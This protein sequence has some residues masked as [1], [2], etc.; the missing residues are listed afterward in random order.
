MQDFIVIRGA[1]EN[2]LKNINLKIPR[3]KLNVITGLSGSGKSSLAFDTIYAEGQRRYIESLSSYARQFLGQ[4][5]KPNVESIEGLSPAISIDQKTTSKNPRS[6]VGTVTEIHDYLRL[7]F[8]RIGTPHC[9]ICGSKISKMS[10]DTIVSNILEIKEETKLFIFAPI[11]REKKGEYK[12]VLDAIKREG[13]LRVRVDGKIYS[14]DDDEI[15]P[16]NKQKKHSIDILVDRLMSKNKNNEDYVKRL[17]EGL[18]TAIYK[19]EG[20]V[21]IS[22]HSPK[23]DGS[24]LKQKGKKKNESP[25]ELVFNTKL[26]CPNDGFSMEELEPKM[27]SFNSPFGACPTCLGLGIIQDINEDLIIVDK[28]LSVENGAL[29]RIFGNMEFVGYYKQEIRALFK[30]E[31]VDINLPYNKLSRKFKDKL[32]YGTGEE[33]ISYEYTSTNTGRVTKMNHSFEGLLNN[34]KRRYQNTNSDYIKRKIEEYMNI[35]ECPECKGKRYKKEILFVTIGKEKLNIS[36][37]SEK[38]IKQALEY[39]KNLKLNEREEKIAHLIVKEIINRLGFLDNIGLNYLSLS[40]AAGTL[41]GGESGRIRLATQI[42][43]QLMG[44][45]YIL[46]EPSIGLHQRDNKKLLSALRS[47]T[48]LGNTLIVVEH[49]EETMVEAD[50]IIDIGRGAGKYGGKVVFTGT[51]SEIKKCKESLTGQYLAKKLKMDVP[52]KKRKDIKKEIKVIGAKENNLKNIDVSFPLGKF[53]VVSGVS[54]SGKSSL[55]NE[56]LYKGVYKKLKKSKIETGAFKEIKGISNIDNIIDINQSP[57]GRTP[58]SN[59]ATYTGAFDYIRDLFASLNASK[60]RGYTKSRFSFNVPGGRCENCK[61]EGLIKIK[62]HFLADI[63]VPC[64]V[65]KGKRYNNETLSVKYKGKSIY[66]VLNMEVGEGLSFFEN[67][68]NIH[69][70]LKTLNDVGL[71]YIKIGQPSTTLSGGEAQRVKLATEL[72]KKETGNTLYILDEPTT[73]LHF[74]DVKK[75][76]NILT[77]LVDKGN[78]V[79]VIEHNLDVIRA[80]DYIIDIGPEGGEEGGRVIA[81][82]TPEEIVKN[83]NSIT[84]KCLYN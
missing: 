1:N 9:P 39:F 68:P 45:L 21:F 16:L 22:L 37:I 63:Y 3:N 83:K 79:I 25:K 34:L 12:K 31:G 64:E 74:D 28:N 60:V 4:M 35:K 27:F 53:V 84:G 19:G 58:R 72:S 11:I 52:K 65:C 43:S 2:N 73:G 77:R 44:V 23:K 36:D 15:P 81:K 48:D 71:G 50:N 32:L 42:G 17:T 5:E 13:F 80:A 14:F 40:R 82:G 75:L 78:S 41:S 56:V 26:S 47:M 62:M 24:N 46:D 55:V 30:Q 69:N 20:L 54:G 38:S 67:I 66:D 7:L 57:I 8:A 70:I 59:P 29:G 10:I 18:E 76:I 6:T 61:G 51:Y 49:D 33:K